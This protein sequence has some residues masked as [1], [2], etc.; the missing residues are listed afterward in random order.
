MRRRFAAGET[1]DGEVE[2]APEEMH[3]AHLA[4]EAPAEGGEDARP[5]HEK[6]PEAVR[7]LRVIGGMEA[8]LL[9]GN[10]VGDLNRHGPDLDP[11]PHRGEPAHELGVELAT[12]IGASAKPSVAPSLA[13]ILRRWAMKSNSISKKRA[14]CGIGEVVRPQE[15]T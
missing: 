15:L 1:G 9:E 12:L 8:I 13:P 14:P 3:R 2:A 7:L 10:R 4:G 5:L 6:A 11:Q